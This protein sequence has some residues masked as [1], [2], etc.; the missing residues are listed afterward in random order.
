M[1]AV[2]EHKAVARSLG[3]RPRDRPRQRWNDG[4]E[5]DLKGVN[6]RSG[7]GPEWTAIRVS[8]GRRRIYFSAYSFFETRL[9]LLIHLIRIR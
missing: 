6:F 3:K 1:T 5:K 4:I 2:G 7:D 9:F 8:L